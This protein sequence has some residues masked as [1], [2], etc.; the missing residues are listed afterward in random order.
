MNPGVPLKEIRMV[1]LGVIRPTYRTSKP[2]APKGVSAKLLFLQGWS[3]LLA[4]F[5]M[6]FQ[7]RPKIAGVPLKETTTWVVIFGVICLSH[8]QAKKLEALF[9]FLLGRPELLASLE[10]PSKRRHGGV[11]AKLLKLRQGF[12]IGIPS[13]PPFFVGIP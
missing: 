2:N 11:S 7:N 3:Q 4:S 13:E 6:F 8:Q 5:T 12:L 9:D 1:S 10:F